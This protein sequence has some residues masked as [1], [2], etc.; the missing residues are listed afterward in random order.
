MIQPTHIM[1]SSKGLVTTSKPS[2]RELLLTCTLD[3]PPEKV[4]RAWTDPEL[5]KQWFAPQPWSISD[6]EMDF[7]PGG[8]SFF[9]MNGPEGEKFPCPGVVLEVVPNRR[10][11]TTDAYT[12]GWKPAEKPFMTTIVTFDPAP[13]GKT[14]Y[15]ARVLH[16]TSA[17]CESHEKMGFHE[18]WAV[19]A[20]QLAELVKR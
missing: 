2:D 11:V 9:N 19:C 5:L 14:N 16:W 4:Y 20:E 17:D 3:A 12:E 8:K 1:S 18:G 6:I 10:I 15:T 7:R 13:G